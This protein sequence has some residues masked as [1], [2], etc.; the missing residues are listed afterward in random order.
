METRTRSV[1][2][3]RKESQGNV[4]MVCKELKNLKSKKAKVLK[5][6]ILECLRRNEE[7]RSKQKETQPKAN[8]EEARPQQQIVFM[9]DEAV[10]LGIL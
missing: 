5:D 7:A 1:S 9:D 4:E 2:R 10:V 8:K 6:H 3:R